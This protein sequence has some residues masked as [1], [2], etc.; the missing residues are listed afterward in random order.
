MT[1]TDT[2]EWWELLPAGIRDEVDGFVLQDARMRAV[3]AVLEVTRARGLGLHDA[4][5]LVHG[6]YLHHGD[7][8]ART[9][10]SPLDQESLVAR[11]AGCPGRIVAIEAVWD[12]DTVHDWFVNLLALTDDPVGERALATVYRGT[13]E[14]YL[15]A[16]RTDAARGAGTEAATTSEVRRRQRGGGAVRGRR[17]PSAAVA[18]QVGGALA[19]A[20]SVPFHFASPDDPDDTAPRLRS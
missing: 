19:A 15:E 14:R 1:D 16:E 11:A 10:D 3:L 8:V 20:L 12:G 2:S 18:E 7:R 17:H 4:E 5:R 6:R 13:A 9:P